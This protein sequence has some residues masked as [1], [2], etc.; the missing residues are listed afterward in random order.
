M[1]LAP[2]NNQVTHVLSFASP[3]TRKQGDFKLG[4]E[5]D[6]SAAYVGGGTSIEND[7]DSRFVNLGGRLD[8]NRKQ[9]TI[10]LGLSYTNSDT[11]A[12]LDP[13]SIYYIGID[14]YGKKNQ[15]F[16]ECCVRL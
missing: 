12:M 8:F 11:H 7:Y 3:E 9:T 2:K 15:K 14:N 1:S 10:N 4:Y 5:W 16:Q 13:D 6:E